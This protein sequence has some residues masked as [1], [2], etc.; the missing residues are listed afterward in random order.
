MLT[1]AL[2]DAI[3]PLSFGAHVE[4]PG[5]LGY[6]E[7]FSRA[8]DRFSALGHHRVI[9]GYGRRIRVNAG[10]HDLIERAKRINKSEMNVIHGHAPPLEEGGACE[11]RICLGAG[12]LSAV[13][14]QEL[15]ADDVEH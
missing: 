4:Y 3:P 11:A 13:G 9:L 6:R 7:P 14:A 5:G 1:G 10:F 15:F 2:T 12:C 8:C